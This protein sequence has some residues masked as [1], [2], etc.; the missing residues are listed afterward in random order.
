MISDL[1]ALTPPLIVCAAF[2]IGLVMFLRRQ[3]GPAAKAPEADDD[4]T[5]IPTESG[6]DPTGGQG[7]GDPARSPT[8]R[9]GQGMNYFLSR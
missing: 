5:N 1:A 9:S 6:A 4:D 8:R 7:N 2:I 3:M